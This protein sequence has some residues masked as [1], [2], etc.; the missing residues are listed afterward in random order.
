[1]SENKK[2]NPAHKTIDGPAGVSINH[3]A[4]RPSK[5]A[6]EPIRLAK[7]AICSGVCE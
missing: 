6:K 2:S 3:D 7:I 4:D 1:V 5:T